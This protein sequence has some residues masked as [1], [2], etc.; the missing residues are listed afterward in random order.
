MQNNSLPLK[1][2]LI[3]VYPSLVPSKLSINIKCL[4]NK[5]R[6]VQLKLIINDLFLGTNFTS[7]KNSTLMVLEYCSCMGMDKL[8]GQHVE[9]DGVCVV[10]M[11]Q[12]LIRHK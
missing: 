5:L 11:Q 6:V 2:Y 1:H 12:I 8:N 4:S 10:K 3:F 7:Q 9:V